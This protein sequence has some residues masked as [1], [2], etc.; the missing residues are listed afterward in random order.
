MANALEVTY[1]MPMDLIKNEKN[2]RTHSEQQ[3]EQIKRSINEFGF[4]NP[5]LVDEQ[6]VV[7]AGHGRLEAASDM[8]LDAVPTILLAGLSEEQKQAYVIADNQI[9]LNSEWDVEKLAEALSDLDDSLFDL[10]LLGFSDNDLADLILK[11]TEITPTEENPYSMNIEAPN[12]EPTGEKPNLT[13]L[14]DLSYTSQLVEN[15]RKSSI[16]K[17]EK[18]FLLL[19]AERHTVFNFAKIANYYAQ[20][21]AE[22][23]QLMEDSALVI[24]DYNQALEKGFVQ[25][26]REMVEQYED[27]IDAHD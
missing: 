23:Q 21:G 11:E 13:D 17:A 27:E 24:I 8:G 20:S 9:A 18:D 19:A 5:I 16:T 14:T 22:M 6:N 26:N 10:D 4:T 3:I 25:I 7:I 15:I 12:Y 2:T 1:Q